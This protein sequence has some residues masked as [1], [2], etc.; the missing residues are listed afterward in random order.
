MSMRARALYGALGIA[1]ALGVWPVSAAATDVY[2]NGTRVNGLLRN[3]TFKNATVKFGAQGNVFIDAPGYTVQIYDAAG[4][5]RVRPQGR[6][7]VVV[8]VPSPGHYALQV[9]ANG[10]RI[11][12]V[13]ATSRQHVAELTDALEIGRNDVVVTF[14]PT[15]GAPNISGSPIDAVDIMLGQ[16]TESADGTLTV[17]KVLANYK[18]K[19][20]QASAIAHS[21]PFELKK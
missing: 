7:W 11:A 5:G 21:I 1:M 19:T 12:D 3:Q 6:F 10:K 13:P 14:M 8:N 16:G 18:H 15:P 20:G 4:S 9:T 17:S 2:L